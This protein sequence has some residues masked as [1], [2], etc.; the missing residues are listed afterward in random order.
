MASENSQ[1]IELKRENFR[2]T[3][4]MKALQLA[5]VPSFAASK[6]QMNEGR[7]ANDD[8]DDDEDNVHV[9][10]SVSGAESATVSGV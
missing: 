9:L 8:A 5:G 1:R 7:I 6:M 2:A 4:D 10:V 3:A